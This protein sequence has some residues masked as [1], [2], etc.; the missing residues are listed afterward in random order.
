MKWTKEE[1]KL[2]RDNWEELSDKELQTIIPNH[3]LSSITTKRKDMDLKRPCYKKYSFD[4]VIYYISKKGY[5]LISKESDFKNAG[6]KIKYICQNHVD[7]GIQTTTFG[8]LLEGKGCKYCGIQTTRDKRMVSLDKMGHKLLAVLRN[9][10]YVDSIRNNGVICIKFICNNHKDLG[11]QVMSVKNMERDIK[12]C[13]FCSSKELPEWYVIKKANEINPYMQ[14]LEPYQNLTHRTKCLCTK[15]NVVANKTMQE[16]LKGQGC[17]FC[18]IEKLSFLHT[19][20]IDEYRDR[21]YLVNKNVEVLEYIGMA[22]KA[23]FRCKLCGHEWY[24]HAGVMAE[25][26]TQCPKCCR[27]YKGEKIIKNILDKWGYIYEEQ[28]R[29]PDCIDKRCLPFDIY[30]PDY[31]TIIEYDGE[32][33][34]RPVWGIKSFTMTVK[35]DEIKNNYCEVNNISLIRITYKDEDIEYKLFDELVKIGVIIETTTSIA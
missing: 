25:D 11:E 18:G 32:Q 15:H 27:Y 13:K 4:D 31:N 5:K 10:T 1:E 17:Y 35:H 23:K 3:S 21:V 8:H 6:T 24:A 16:I 30:L 28:K 2:I 7:E 33:H 9:F 19:L 29:F 26:G 14:L 12:G 34:F 20:T 22:S